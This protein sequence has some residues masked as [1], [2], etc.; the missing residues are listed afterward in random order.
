DE[1]ALAEALHKGLIAGAGLDVFEEEPKV[2]PKLLNA[3]NAILLPHIASATHKT[4]EAIGMLAANAIVSVLEGKADS[5]IPNLI[6][7]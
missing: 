3:P 1:A 5:E 4:R 2:H 7:P 6:S